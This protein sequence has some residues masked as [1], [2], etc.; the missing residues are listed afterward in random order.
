MTVPLLGLD[1]G[2]YIK[3]AEMILHHPFQLCLELARNKDSQTDFDSLL[4][5]LV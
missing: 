2:G 4:R 3:S 5:R 1:C